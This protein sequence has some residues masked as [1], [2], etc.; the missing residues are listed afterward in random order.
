MLSILPLSQ[1]TAERCREAAALLFAHLP[2]ADRDERAEHF[3]AA[4][5]RND[6]NAATILTAWLHDCIFGVQVVELL[7]GN[8]AALWAIRAR[9]GDE[10]R[11][12]EDALLQAA[13]ELM[14]TAGMKMAQCLL[15]PDEEA[16]AEAVRRAGLTRLT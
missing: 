7:A 10:R 1:L 8:S 16:A 4:V 14:R 6:L 5:N 2:A 11:K 9:P 15:M 13:L 12:V 3:L